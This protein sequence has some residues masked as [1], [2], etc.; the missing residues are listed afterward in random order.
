MS[1]YEDLAE[2]CMWA[3]DGPRDF[4]GW[5]V[6]QVRPRGPVGTRTMQKNHP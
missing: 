1:Y 5:G 2:I 6:P 3:P 4:Y